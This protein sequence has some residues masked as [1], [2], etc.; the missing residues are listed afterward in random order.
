MPF[1]ASENSSVANVR[2][3][4]SVAREKQGAP[5]DASTPPVQPLAGSLDGQLWFVV[6]G[7][8]ADIIDGH[9]NSDGSNITTTFLNVPANPGAG[10]QQG[11]TDLSIGLDLP[12]G[13]YF[14]ANSDGLS[15]SV[16]SITTGALIDTLQIANFNGST[17][18][19]EI[20]NSLVVDP[21]N[22]FVY[23]GIWGNS[24]AESGVIRISY[25]AAGALDHNQAYNSGSQTMLVNGSQA[26]NLTDLRY[27]D[28]SNNNQV[29]YVTDNDNHYTI[30][31]FSAKNGIYKVD[32]TNPAAGATL[33]SSQVQFPIDLT[34]GLL[35]SVTADE[36]DGIIYF[37]SHQFNAGG[38]NGTQDALW[39][40]PI[41]GG[42]ATKITLPAGALHYAGEWGGLS[43]DRQTG[44]LYI[45]DEDPTANTVPN[46]TAGRHIIQ[47][48][49]S[50]DGK[51]VTSTVNTHTVNQLVAH[52][53]DPNAY[54][55]GTSFDLLPVIT[56]TGTATHAA[57]QGA[58]IDLTGAVS[59][60]ATDADNNFLA[61]ATVQITGGTFV[62]N[63]TS[64]NDDHLT[65]NDGGVFKT[66]GTFTGTSI[67]IS[68]NGAAEKLTLSGVDTPA[69]YQTVLNAVSY[70][71]TGD[72]PTNYGNN[73]FR[74]VTW[75]L[76]DGA[77]NVPDGGQNQTTTTLNID[78]VNDP[79][80]N[81]VPVGLQT[82]M[83]GSNLAFPTLHVSDPDDDP[84]SASQKVVVTLGVLHGK[85]TVL[86]NV[87][88]GLV[89]G[90]VSNNGTGTVTITATQ[91]AINNTFAAANGVLYKS[92]LY[93]GAETFTITSNDQG[94]TGSGGPQSDLDTVSITVTAPLIDYAEQ[95]PGT[96]GGNDPCYP[97]IQSAITDVASG[98]TVNVV[99]GV[100]N[101]SVT[102]NKNAT[103][104]IKGGT[105]INDFTLTSGT[106]NGS[107][108]GSFTLTLAVGNW[109][110]NGGT[111]TPGTGTVTFA[112]NGTSQAISGNN[113][114][115]NLT[116][117]HVGLNGV[118]AAGSTLAVT[119]T[120]DVQNGTFTSS[121][122]YNNVQID[123]G[124]TFVS[125]GSTINV[126]GSWTNNGGT[127]TPAGCTVNFNGSGTQSIGGSATSQAFDN[128]TVNK[129][130]GSI[131]SVAASTAT[132]DINGN[133]TLTL[134]TLAAGTANAITVAG[135]WTN[136]GG[137]FT[138]GAGTVTFDGAAGQI[139][140]GTMATTFFNLTNSDASGI[141]MN[142][143]NNVNG[144]LALTS[145][146][147]TVANTKTLTQASTIASTG[148][149]DVVGTVKRTGT[150]LSSGVP[151]TFGNPN[152]RITFTGGTAPTDMSVT[153]AKTAPPTYAAAVL[154][155]YTVATSGGSGSTATWRLRYIDPDD[156]NG[157]TE[158]QLNLRRLRTSDSHWTAQLPDTV[159]VVNNYVEATLVPAA[160]LPTQWT[161]SS[162]IPT[163]TGGVVTGRIVDQ[164]GVPVEGAVV[165]LQGTQNRKFITDA[166]GIYRF[167][168]VETSGFYTVTPS[169]PNYT[170]SP[171]VRSFSQVGE[172]TEAAF[173][174]TL[175][176]GNFENPLD[177]PEYFVRQ[178]Y[179]D[180][181]GREPDEAG[182]NFWSDQI[183]ECGADMQCIDR[184]RENVSAAYF[185]SIEFQQTGG[186]VDGMYR[187]S[188]GVR[189]GF[190][191]F[192]PD[193]R[194]VGLGVIV[195]EDGWQAKLAANK[196]AFVTAFVNRPAFH[197]QYD[198]MDNSLFVET[199]IGHTGVSFTVEE[200]DALAN[201]L[202]TGTMTRADVVR[203][204]AENG[205]FVQAKFNDAFVM[206]EYFGYLR[207]DPDAGGFAFWLTKLNEFNGNFEQAEMVRAFIVSSEY[208][209][210]F[211]R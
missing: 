144:T 176:S 88:S 89:P 167:D 103:V 204:I 63:E 209:D 146:D 194:A 118:T 55:L 185:L 2:S 174:A 61:S 14:V 93:Q 13:L 172:T 147:I 195:G 65:V 50:A 210:R 122:N 59:T 3:T 1:A 138:A 30:A 64:A 92:G 105:T 192:M 76:S 43:Y 87:A 101:E 48:Q 175:S 36:E 121:S 142:N 32:L 70:N 98:G 183:L 7:A 177:T 18:A 206:M 104:N 161:F 117:N 40:M 38:P 81:T 211:P 191:E 75:T 72:N 140:D 203:S 120:L 179:L 22:R 34:Q 200:R 99:G 169:R 168:N 159:D 95:S 208:R 78:A 52:T 126:S 20:V 123:S 26:G 24:L 28:L 186:L 162:L 90:D 79:P 68:Y 163:A 207:R 130:G 157:N 80:V 143:D 83:E 180:F 94:N 27:M 184:R 51:S 108:G 23:A 102:L 16:Q 181:L 173:G 141:A 128:F 196:E 71:T 111:F 155:T 198:G 190:A 154:R 151:L 17:A 47:L 188:Y 31:P 46:P 91:N 201:G 37:T 86:T 152:N 156:L 125:D 53:A 44:Q 148:T 15:I 29:L 6:Q 110:R 58:T 45:S 137:S 132:L 42:T 84:A 49:M 33:L 10:F 82:V 8:I 9:V 170:F 85:V 25:T 62:S 136:N 139:I 74:T 39:W 112:G 73:A 100:F 158:A 96:C 21:N 12:D 178:H 150:P 116:I 107:N 67:T 193:T 109:T 119:G 199:L 57:E 135:N 187:A 153:L 56:V 129:S 164:N 133:L 134:G 114:F 165:R 97:S 149:F 106:L 69:H 189:P 127:F 11:G 66:S 160:N 166:N 4:G 35:G 115:N 113:T 182:F 19:Q 145:S 205:R 5:V 131:L 124:G 54:P 77:P 60:S 171:T 202:A 41:A 197:A